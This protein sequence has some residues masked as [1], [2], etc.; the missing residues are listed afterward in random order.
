MGRLGHHQLRHVLTH[1]AVGEQPER[2]RQFLGEVAGEGELAGA[3]PRRGAGG[4]ADLFP[5]A[6]PEPAVVHPVGLL[7]RNLRPGEPHDLRAL[8]RARGRPHPLQQRDP[9]DPDGVRHAGRS[10]R[11]TPQRRQ[12]L[13]QPTGDGV[14][15]RRAPLG[16]DLHCRRHRKNATDAH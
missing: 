8:R 14:V 1:P 16:L 7:L 9:V 6:L 2:L 13:T 4:Q 11:Q 12:H 3:V 15:V 5:D 10:G